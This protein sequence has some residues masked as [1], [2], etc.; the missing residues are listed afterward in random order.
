MSERASGIKSVPKQ[1]Q[2]NQPSVQISIHYPYCLEAV[3]PADLANMFLD[4]S[5]KHAKSTQT[6]PSQLGPSSCEQALLPTVPLCQ[7]TKKFGPIQ[8]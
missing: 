4:Y 5:K 7:P 6:D 8:L 2:E 1:K 3:A